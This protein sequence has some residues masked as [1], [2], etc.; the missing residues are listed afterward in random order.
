MRGVTP[1]FAVGDRT[2]LAA[3][4]RDTAPL[5]VS[6]IV[7]NYN[8][9]RW[10]E[11]CLPAAIAQL[12]AST[13]LIVVDNESTDGSVDYV[14]GCFPEAVLVALGA[15]LG[16]AGGNNVGARHA[17][18][19]YL[20]FLNN[21][22]APQEGWLAALRAVLDTQRDAGMAASRIVYRDD[23]S[24]VDSA[25]DGLTRVGGA[26]KR[27]HGRPASE[28]R[29]AGDVFG[30]CGAAFL[31]RRELFDEL[32]GFDE[33]FFAVYEDVD[34]SYRSQLLGFRCRYVPDAVVHHAG[35]GTLGRS[36]P[37]AV[38]LGQ[39]NL[40]WMYFKNTPWPLLI[41]TMPGHLVYGVAAAL[42]FARTGHF[43]TFLSAKRHAMAGAA[44]V[45]HERRTVQRQ[46]RAGLSRLWRLMEPRWLAVK[47]REKR[48]D[49]G[50]APHG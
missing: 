26:F 35:S 6:I 10:L 31:I 43:R 18:G 46:R 42:H 21:D 20:A 36:S 11:R 40:E 30:A 34:L 32:Q 44:R 23:P 4:S 33:A 45:W 49:L 28:A 38:F 17:R 15:N 14:R 39:R 47:L 12:D 7:V 13:E 22:A 19:R 9:R 41:L 48:F 2:Q 8:G 25:G 27:S 50:A 37:Q 16:F 1:G 29:A 3:A 24:V 5:A